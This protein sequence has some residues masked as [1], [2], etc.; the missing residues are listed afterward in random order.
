MP[1]WK[2]QFIGSCCAGIELDS[3]TEDEEGAEMSI[4]DRLLSQ[5]ARVIGLK[6]KPIEVEE[7]KAQSASKCI[8]IVKAL[9]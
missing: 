3:D 8:Y 2:S 4:K 6:K 1:L 9:S 5:V 7:R